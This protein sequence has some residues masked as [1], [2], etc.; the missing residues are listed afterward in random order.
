MTYAEFS[1]AL[2]GGRGPSCV[3]SG[4]GSGQRGEGS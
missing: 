1:G 4:R 3:A 2:D